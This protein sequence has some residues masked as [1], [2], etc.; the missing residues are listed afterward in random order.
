MSGYELV[1][2][3]ID[4][5]GQ[6]FIALTNTTWENL[7]REGTLKTDLIL[8]CGDEPRRHASAI[9]TTEKG[10]VI[11]Y[12]MAEG[13]DISVYYN[14]FAVKSLSAVKY[15]LWN[16][17]FCIGDIRENLQDNRIRIHRMDSFRYK[18]KVYLTY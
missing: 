18:G 6:V 8:L 4:D 10:V 16:S 3:D 11:G 7:G 2:F 15:L 17:V 1:K 14:D 5:W 13:W 9:V 12:E